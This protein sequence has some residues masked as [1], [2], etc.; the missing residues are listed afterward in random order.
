MNIDVTS[1]SLELAY[2]KGMLAAENQVP[3]PKA[4]YD[5]VS[6]PNTMAYDSPA[7]L[8]A[9]AVGVIAVGTL[10]LGSEPVD[11]SKLQAIIIAADTPNGT[12]EVYSRLREAIVAAGIPQLD[13]E[14]LRDEIRERKGLQAE[15]VA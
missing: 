7:I 8:R 13:D 15:S 2:I 4:N 6:F 10:T 14:A 11:L 3:V 1:E 12:A 9:I 5:G